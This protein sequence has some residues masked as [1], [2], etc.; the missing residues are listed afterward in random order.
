MDTSQLHRHGGGSTAKRGMGLVLLRMWHEG[1][2][3][4]C[5]TAKLWGHTRHGNKAQVKLESSKG[6][7]YMVST[8]GKLLGE[9]TCRPCQVTESLR[10]QQTS[11]II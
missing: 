1:E 11:K 6:V 2:E 7:I 5:S 8:K 10:L 4:M 9:A 3:G